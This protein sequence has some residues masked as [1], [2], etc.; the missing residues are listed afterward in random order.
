[1]GFVKTPEEIDRIE[2]AL[3]SARWSGERLAVQFLTSE[4][5]V[6]NLLPPP[7]EPA[8]EPLVTATVGRWQSSCLGF[9][10][11][12]VVNFAASYEGVAGSYLLA[13]YMDSEP[14]TVFGRELFGEPKK[15]ATSGLFRDGDLVQGWIRRHGVTLIALE[16]EIGEDLGSSASERYT[17][18]YKAR[19]A[20]GG[21]GLEEDAI[22]TRAHFAVQTRSRHSGTGT[23]VLGHGP[24]DPLD[25]IEVLEVRAVDYGQDDSTP[26]CAPV[27]TVPAAQFLPYHYGRQDDWTAL[28]TTMAMTMSGAGTR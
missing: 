4:E 19:T 6:R 2:D 10:S 28:D 9:F 15:S 1:M 20:A 14:A 5:T 3:S 7:L 17:Y 22:L 13:I 25:E 11:G 8:P 27:A 21:R 24:H 12:G 23:V 16:A 18:N 26:H